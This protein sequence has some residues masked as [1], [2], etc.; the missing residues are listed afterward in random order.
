VKNGNQTQLRFKAR[1]QVLVLDLDKAGHVR[2]PFYVRRKI[3]E[4]ID[5]R[6]YFLNP[7]QL[8]IG[9]TAGP[10]VALYRVRFMMKDLWPNYDQDR[11]D[12]LCI[13]V[14]DHWLAPIANDE[15]RP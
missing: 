8:S 11:T 14:Y 1:D 12:V 3:G 13:E 5:F 6:G 7:E 9:N 4:V 10:V 15:A 2:T